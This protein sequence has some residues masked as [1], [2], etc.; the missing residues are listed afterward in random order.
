M[1]LKLVT[2]RQA[3]RLVTGLTDLTGKGFDSLLRSGSSE[4]SARHTSQSHSRSTASTT[5]CRGVVVPSGHLSS[6]HHSLSCAQFAELTKILILYLLQR[7]LDNEL[8]YYQF[9]ANKPP[10]LICHNLSR[11]ETALLKN[12]E[13]ILIT[14]TIAYDGPPHLTFLSAAIGTRSR[15]HGCRVSK[16]VRRRFIDVSLCQRNNRPLRPRLKYFTH[17]QMGTKYAM[18]LSV[19]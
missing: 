4:G 12:N 15:R 2:R 17:V 6:E 11:L 7:K 1:A 5:W 8:N 16:A 10:D 13:T 3:R 14:V 19:T 18:I 9:A